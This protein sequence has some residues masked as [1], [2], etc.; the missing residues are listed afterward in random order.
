[1][2]TT[3][4]IYSHL[5]FVAL[6]CLILNNIKQYGTNIENKKWQQNMRHG[7]DERFNEINTLSVRAKRNADRLELLQSH[8]RRRRRHHYDESF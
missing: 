7:C 6:I 1:M 2:Q 5:T 4:Q 8:G 3:I